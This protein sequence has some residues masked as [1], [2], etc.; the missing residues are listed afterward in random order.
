LAEEH[1]REVRWKPV[2]LGAIFKALGSAYLLADQID[3]RPGKIAGTT[4]EATR[5]A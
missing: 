1:G 5:C 2:A 4:F 3:G